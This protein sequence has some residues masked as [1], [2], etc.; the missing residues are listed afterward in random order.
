MTATSRISKGRYRV[1]AHTDW[2]IEYL[3]TRTSEKPFSCLR[4]ILNR[5]IQNDHAHYEG[6]KGAKQKFKDFVAP[7]D[8]AEQKAI[9]VKNIPIIWVAST[10]WMK[11]SGASAIHCKS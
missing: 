9:G 1:D 5:I 11:T 2:V 10:A 4:P 7:G 6:P 8:L 3:K